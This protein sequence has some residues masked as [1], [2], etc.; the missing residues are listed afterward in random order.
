MP[1]LTY[2]NSIIWSTPTV[3]LIL[4]AGIFFTLRLKLPQINFKKMLSALKSGGDGKALSPVQALSTSLAAT[5]GTGSITGVAAA[6]TLGGPGAVFW[7][8]VSAFF[9]MAVAYAE[10]VLSVKYRQTQGKPPKGGIWFALEKGLGAKKLAVAYTFFCVMASFG[11]GCMAQTNSA[12][13][14]LYRGFELPKGLFGAFAAVL[15]AVCIGGS[16]RFTGCLCEKLIPLLAGFYV[17]G[18]AAVI[19]ANYQALPEVLGDIFRSAL[20]LQPLV[21]GAAGYSI[22]TAIS[23]GCRKGIFSNEAG[24]G[25][26]AAVHASSTVKDPD[27]QGGMNMLEVVIDTFV[28]CT[29]T[30]LAILCSG[31]AKTGAEGADLVILAAENVFGVISGKLVA[32]CLAG[33]ALATAIGWTQIGGAAAEYLFG[34]KVGFYRVLYVFAAFTGS[35]ISLGAAFELSDIF[36][37]LMVLPCMSALILL[38]GE[39]I[40][41]SEKA[42]NKSNENS[43]GSATAPILKSQ[44]KRMNQ[45]RPVEP[46]P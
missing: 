42:E 15:V 4:G 45:N 1:Y 6:I 31:A 25:T 23:V 24:L 43:A 27:A 13:A 46:K 34:K 40:E 14:A 5:V 9:G 8:W 3:C 12:A 7:L 21:G 16:G 22:K 19:A 2:I 39:V 33:F 29:L 38:S 11:M 37:G 32:L 10:G 28:I 36:N 30:A 18:A 17:I 35:M 20:G 41:A 26:T 44:N